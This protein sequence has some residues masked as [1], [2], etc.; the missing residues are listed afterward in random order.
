[1]FACQVLPPIIHGPYGPHTGRSSR[2]QT[3]LTT[4]PT[5]YPGTAYLNAAGIYCHQNLNF[6]WP[7]LFSHLFWVEHRKGHDVFHCDIHCYFVTMNSALDPAYVN[8]LPPLVTCV[9]PTPRAMEQQ[10]SGTST[11]TT[12]NDDFPHPRNLTEFPEVLDTASST[13]TFRARYLRDMT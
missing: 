8:I 9:I 4:V 7:S 2:H 3:C 11:G 12:F 1:M 6:N 13:A 10:W 5:N